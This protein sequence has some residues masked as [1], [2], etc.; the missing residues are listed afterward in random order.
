M[1]DAYDPNAGID[2][3][4]LPDEDE[5]LGDGQTQG[6][7]QPGQG[8]TTFVPTDEWQEVPEGAI[9]PPG[10][11]I[12]MDQATGKT[13]ARKMRDSEKVEEAAAD[14]D[15][16]PTEGQKEAG[17]YQHGH[18][19]FQ[20]IDIAIETVRG[21]ERT[22]V[23]PNGKVGYDAGALWQD[24]AHQGRGRRSGG[25]LYWPRRHQPNGIRS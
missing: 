19:R 8:D 1:P 13:Y 3:T 5:D 20:G 9:L 21:Q 23:D 10:L 7:D 18:V 24:Q 2:L 15:P 11:H 14:V 6:Q 12:Q 22:G 4:P 16:N 17:N 25:C